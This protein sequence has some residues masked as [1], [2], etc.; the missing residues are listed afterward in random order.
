MFTDML[1]SYCFSIR[2]YSLT[3]HDDLPS[4]KVFKGEIARLR[5]FENQRPY[6]KLFSHRYGT[7][8]YDKL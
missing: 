6:V 4:D 2:Q 8:I 1:L 5:S 3:V 7:V